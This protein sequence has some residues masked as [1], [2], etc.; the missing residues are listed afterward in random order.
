[1]ILKPIKLN[2]YIL[3]NRIVLAP[4]STQLAQNDGSIS[5]RMIAYYGE[6]AHGGASMLIT[7]TFHIDDKA[8]RFTPAQPSL[9]HDRFIPG[10]NILADE[11]QKEGAIAIAQ[12][13]HAGRQTEYWVNNYQPVA[14]TRITGGL[15]D[16]CHELTIEEIEELIGAFANCAYR[17]DIAGFNGVEIHGGN[18]YLINEF[19]SPLT[20]K[21]KD[22]YGKNKELFLKRIILAVKEKVSKYC[23]IG[24]RIGFSDFMEGGLEPED[25]TSMCSLLPLDIIDY[26]HVCGGV[27]ETDDYRIQPIYQERAV[28]RMI[29]KELKK[30]VSVPIILTGSINNPEL[31]EELIQ[32][33]DADLIGMGRQLLADNE[34][35]NKLAGRSHGAFRPCIRCNYGCLDR[36][37]LSKTIKCSVNPLTGNEISY[38]GFT[39]KKNGKLVLVAGGGPA[40]IITALRADELGYNVVLYEQEKTL[41]GLLRT[42]LHEDFKQ[43]IKDYLHYLIETVFNS[44][45]QIIIDNK[46][47]SRLIEES[48]PDLFIDATGSLPI[49][50]EIPNNLSYEIIESR[51]IL[52]KLDNYF[53]KQ[54]VVII[55]G[56]SVGCEIGYALA[57]KGSTVTVIEQTSDILMDMDPVSSLS[58]TRNM[59]SCGVEIKM[60]SL[61]KN[62][63]PDGVLIDKND[64]PITANLVVVAMGSKRSQQFNDI[65][66]Q[67]KYGVNY[68]QVGDALR[69]GRIYNA[70]NDT[71]WRISSFLG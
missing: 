14:P 69:I 45:V 41:G 63:T 9:Y 10:A 50:P 32:Q 36:V 27:V 30:V 62:F 39:M 12:V 44:G 34:V 6:R 26:I 2:N 19:L 3:K 51:D 65:D 11:I 22:E 43:D 13:G 55:G 52:L 71:Y 20:N 35:P 42:A 61:F 67:W 28:H 58:L 37:R 31:A 48:N 33:K 7:E 64:S 5:E 40:G 23:I 17:A 54:K 46:V 57:Y 66:T 8:S 25:T 29:S 56:G 70:V 60:N 4:M 49:I 47:D 1:M 21:R 59:F 24:V 53:N 18:G 38:H 15:T 68:T 16:H